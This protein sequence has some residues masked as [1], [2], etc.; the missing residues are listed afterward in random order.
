VPARE[1]DIGRDDADDHGQRQVEQLLGDDAPDEQDG[2]AHGD[3]K[4]SER[5]PALCAVRPSAALAKGRDTHYHAELERCPERRRPG[6]ARVPMREEDAKEDRHEG[7]RVL[8]AGTWVDGLWVDGDEEDGDRGDHERDC[9]EGD[10][11]P[12]DK[13]PAAQT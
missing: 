6:G 12:L 7:D 11:T 2:H 10:V 3:L 4:R 9:G 8:E 5:E 13:C 1:D